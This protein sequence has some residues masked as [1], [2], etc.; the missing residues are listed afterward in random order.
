MDE[1]MNREKHAVKSLS[2]RIAMTCPL[3]ITY[4]GFE[5]QAI[6]TCQA[7]QSLGIDAQL[8]DWN[9][10]NDEFDILHLFGGSLHWYRVSSA[11]EKKCRIVIT[12]LGAPKRWKQPIYRWS[13]RTATFFSR[14]LRQQTLYSYTYDT[15]RRAGCIICLNEFQCKFYQLAYDLSPEKMAMVPNGVPASRYNGDASL[16]VK[17][18]GI[19]DYV[20]FTGN[21]VA[22]KRPLQLARL[23]KRHGF[24]GVF[25]GGILNS[26][27]D[28]AY[29]MEFEEAVKD[30]P[31][32]LWIRG[33]AY[34][35]P[36]LD[37]AYAGARVLCLPSID[38]SQPLSAMEAMAAGSPV[39]LADL[40]YAHQAPFKH[41]VRCQPDDDQS[42]EKALKMILEA[43]DRYRTAL[44]ETYSWPNV[45]KEIVKVYQHVMEHGQ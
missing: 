35:D 38:E 21:I 5:L 27:S 43:P 2:V 25:I 16:F 28:R 26:E 36:L 20:L 15:L 31:N 11:A 9:K 1:P 19:H 4:G 37:S 6:Q 22:R 33:L 12:A 3:S 18:Y 13:G 41:V 39:I 7:L 40:P 24:T 17:R 32:L 8:M 45:A 29:A 34:D 42:L 14:I 23:L 44:P 10:P 30:A